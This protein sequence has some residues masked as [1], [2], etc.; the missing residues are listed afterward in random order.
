MPEDSQESRTQTYTKTSQTYQKE[1]TD[2]MCDQTNLNYV[3]LPSQNL[4]K[5]IINE[6][7]ECD[8]DHE[9]LLASKN[10]KQRVTDRFAQSRKSLWNQK[11]FLSGECKVSDAKSK[12]IPPITSGIVPSVLHKNE[13]N[14]L[15]LSQTTNNLQINLCS[16][17]DNLQDLLSVKSSQFQVKSSEHNGN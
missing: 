7:V 1:K 2:S 14:K 16:S 5:A 9:S 15:K 6:E 10:L 17:P 12:K 3:E 4:F 11:A 13:E 8:G